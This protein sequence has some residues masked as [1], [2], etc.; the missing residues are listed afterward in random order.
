MALLIVLIFVL[1]CVLSR[2]TFVGC[3]CVSLL[4]FD[5]VC[6]GFAVL[7]LC[8]G[9]DGCL[10]MVVWVL[11]GYVCCGYCW[12]VFTVVCALLCYGCCYMML[13]G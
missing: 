10:I 4:A 2:F 11:V 3:I 8:C 13:F 12:L 5:L 9:F 7:L 1:W 6:L